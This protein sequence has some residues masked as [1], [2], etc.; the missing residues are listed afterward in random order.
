MRSASGAFLELVI[1]P[2]ETAYAHYIRSNRACKTLD[3]SILRARLDNPAKVRAE[4]GEHLRE[5]RQPATTHEQFGEDAAVIGRALEIAFVE[6][7][8]RQR[9]PAPVDLAAV[10]LPTEDEHGI[11]VAVVQTA[12]SVLGN[13]P[14]ELRERHERDTIE[15]VSEI[16]GEG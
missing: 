10:H 8:R 13:S 3:T 15:I 14:S 6:G 5:R 1:H 9:R 16:G 12:R 4:A 11:A 7:P 2:A